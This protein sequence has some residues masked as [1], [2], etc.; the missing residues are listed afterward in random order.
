MNKLKSMRVF[1]NV[2]FFSATFDLFGG[3]YFTVFVGSNRTITNPP[4][5]PFYAMLIGTFLICFAYLQFM[6]AFNIKRYLVNIGTVIISRVFYGFLFLYFF[7]FVKDFPPTFLLT[8]I[9]D[10]IWVIFYICLVQ[11]SDEIRFRDL[12]FPEREIG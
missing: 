5:H 6:S 9:A 1:T 7:L 4:T 8:A 12:F 3:V 2:V 11:L 10:I